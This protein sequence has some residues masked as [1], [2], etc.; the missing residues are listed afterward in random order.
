M[1]CASKRISV[2]YRQPHFYDKVTD[3]VGNQVS[4]TV[5]FDETGIRW[6]DAFDALCRL[7]DVIEDLVYEQV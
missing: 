7:D 5:W 1:K 2:R 6:F 4:Y 3:E